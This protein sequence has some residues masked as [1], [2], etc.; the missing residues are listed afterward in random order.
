MPA[1]PMPAAQTQAGS[2]AAPPTGRRDLSATFPA[3]ASFA[4][5]MVAALAA[6]GG[7][8][9]TATNPSTIGGTDTAAPI[10]AVVPIAVP[11]SPDPDTSL[12]NTVPVR[13]DAITDKTGAL[14]ARGGKDARS[15]GTAPDATLQLVG[16]QVTTLQPTVTPPPPASQSPVLQSPVPQ[17]TERET[18][19]DGTK[20]ATPTPTVPVAKSSPRSRS[21]A[22]PP[23]IPSLSSMPP[24]DPAPLQ[25]LLPPGPQ[26]SRQVG[27]VRAD[28]GP[29]GR[30]QTPVSITS[31]PAPDA[32]EPSPVKPL[33][34]PVPATAAL[35]P[36]DPGAD[37]L[38]HAAAGQGVVAATAPSTSQARATAVPA[39]ARA[40]PSAAT[41]QV[42]PAVVSLAAGAGGS[43]SMTLRLD[44]ASLGAVQIR[45][46]RSV[47]APA[48]VDITADRPE[49]LALLQGDQHHLQ[50]A[51]DQAGI[52]AEGRQ[53]TFHTAAPSPDSTAQPSRSDIGSG[54]SGQGQTG[55]HGPR[56]RRGPG[57]E[58]ALEGAALP[59]IASGW[60]RAGIDITA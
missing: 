47:D 58:A 27:A 29:A 14:P 16:P 11:S 10:A 24:P 4:D 53:L 8:V 3:P 34:V 59:P 1:P 30:V 19:A 60:L 9:A 46:D 21:P 22:Q 32:T 13:P 18:S 31:P 45:I 44:P 50:Q 48:R 36:A 15:D 56:T 37:A 20:A 35:A 5:S 54:G 33:P 38:L 6:P 43:H 40:A 52:P 42:M 26:P 17:P 49:T 25:A 2:F 12:A 39:G 57:G 23:P 28:A 41:A 7:A 55:Q 51:L